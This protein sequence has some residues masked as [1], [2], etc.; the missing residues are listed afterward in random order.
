MSPN[1]KAP[2]GRPQASLGQRPRCGSRQDTGAL[3]G[4]SNGG[5]RFWNAPSGLNSFS[6]ANPGRCPGLV[7]LCPVGAQEGG[8]A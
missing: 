8:A 1:S 4:R 7:W 5:G 2:T 6:I 3:K